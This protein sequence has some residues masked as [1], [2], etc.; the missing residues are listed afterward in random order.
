MKKSRICLVATGTLLCTGIAG[1]NAVAAASPSDPVSQYLRLGEC[2]PTGQDKYC[3]GI[4]FLSNDK[5]Q[6]R[7]ELRWTLSRPATATQGSPRGVISEYRKMT[8]AER[9]SQISQE[10]KAARLASKQEKQGLADMNRPLGSAP[11]RYEIPNMKK[12]KQ[13]NSR[14]CGPATMQAMALTDNYRNNHSQDYWAVK[15]RY[16]RGPGTT[17]ANLASAINGYTRWDSR[18][19]TYAARSIRSTSYLSY[20]SKNVYKIGYRRGPVIQNPLY[21][22]KYFSYN[23]YDHNT[24][25]YVTAYKYDQH[26]DVVGYMDPYNERD[27]HRGGANGFGAHLTTF[28]NMYNAVRANVSYIIY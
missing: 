10:L 11:Y 24:G 27:F 13:I 14:Y 17:P 7:S 2:V 3:S 1:P 4:G 28:G 18:T 22:R 15:V 25:H 16:A 19:G 5:G 8:D 12:T 20:V 23:R 21:L 26:R 6:W 9:R